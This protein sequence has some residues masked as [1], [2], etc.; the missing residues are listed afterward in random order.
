VSFDTR[1]LTGAADLRAFSHPLRLR[2]LEALEADGPLT[3][4][5]AAARIGTSP[6]NASFH[7][8][9]LARHGFVEEA[10][11]GSGRRRPWQRVRE[12]V[13]VDADALAVDG[14]QELRGLLE[15]LL[16]RHRDA[17]LGWHRVR[18]DH[19]PRWRAGAGELHT[20]AH[21][22]ADELAELSERLHAAFE[23]FA[24]LPRRPGTLPVHVL[25]STL[26]VPGGPRPDQETTP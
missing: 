20:T 19:D 22:T 11:G 15:L 4:T 10:P 5:E 23:P 21:L 7:L 14:R 26:P 8:R 18:D 12:A 17:V 1:P 13:T 16:A 25:L 2:L 3:A 9:L 6:S 24:D